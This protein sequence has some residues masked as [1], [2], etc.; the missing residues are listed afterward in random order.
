MFLWALL[1]NFIFKQAKMRESNQILFILF[2]GFQVI[3]VKYDSFF[4]NDSS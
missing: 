4:Y 2:L 1:R 3:S